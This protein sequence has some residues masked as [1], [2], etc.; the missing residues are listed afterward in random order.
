MIRR[1]LLFVAVL[2]LIVP[3]ALLGLISTEAGSRWLLHRAFT[4]APGQVTVEKTQGRLLDDIVLTGLEYQSATETISIDRISHSWRPAYLL[5]GKLSIADLVISGLEITL[6]KT[7]AKRP[8]PPAD[9]SEFKLPIQLDIGNVLITD[10]QLIR[11]GQVQTV[12]KLQLAAK[13]EGEQFKLQSLLIQSEQLNATATGDVI[14]DKNFPLNLQAD[15]RIKLPDNGVWQGD[16]TIN[17]DMDKLVFVNHLATPFKFNLE[18]HADHV[19]KQPYFNVKGDWQ[20]LVWPVVGNPPQLQSPQGNFALVGLL[21]DYRLKVNGELQQQYVPQA[22]LAFDGKGSLETMTI[23]KLELESSTGVFQLSGKTSWGDIPA[24]ELSATGQQFNPAIIIPELPGSLNFSSRVKGKLAPNNPQIAA[25]IDQLTGQLRKQTV[26]AKGKLALADKQLKVDGLR[27]NSGAN[28][29]AV[30]GLIDQEKGTL[31]FSMDM[32]TLNTL[33]PT[34]AGSLTSKGQV[35]GG[36][37]NPAIQLDAQGKQLKFAQYKLKALALDLDYHPSNQHHSSLSL[38]ANTITSDGIQL[39]KISL[40]GNGTPQRHTLQAEILY[41]HGT[42]STE[43]AGSWVEPR[44]QA[45]LSKLDIAPKDGKSWSLKAKWPLMAEKNPPGFDVKL[46]EGCLVQQSAALCVSGSYLANSDLD[47]Q[48]KAKA[49]PTELFRSFLP[50]QMMVASLI[51]GNV[52]LQRNKNVLAGNFRADTT[53]IQ[54]FIPNQDKLQE[55]QLG[56]STLSGTINKDKVAA[57]FNL[58][59]AGQDFVQGNVLTDIGKVQALSG[60]L[61]AAIADFSLVKPFVP[62]MADIQGV[63]KADLAVQGTINKPLIA[64]RVG[65]SNGLVETDKIGLHHIDLQAVASG[66]RNNVIHIQGSA[67]PIILNP[68]NQDEKISLTS[69]ISLD[70]DLAVQDVMSGNLRLA[71]PANSVLTLASQTGKQD[72]VLG[73]T[74]LTGE[75]NGKALSAQLDMALTGQDKLHGNLQMNADSQALS[76]Q[77]TANIREFVLLEAFVPLLSKVKG[78]LKADMAVGGTV[79]KPSVN[80][81]VRLKDASFLV[82]DYGL[83]IH[84]INL[85]TLAS[86]IRNDLIEIEGSAKSGEGSIKLLGN[87]SLAPEQGYP[88]QL[89]LTGKDFEI[90]KMP[91]AQ[92]AVSPDLTLALTRQQHQISGQLDIPKA[93]LTLEDIPENAVK[94][95]ADEVILGEEQPEGN[96]ELPAP[97]VNVDIEVKLGKQVS[98]SG[99][100]L[101]TNLTGNLK[102]TKPEDKMGMQGNVNMVKAKYQRF[103]QDLTVRKGRF[104]FNGPADNPWLDV[105]AIRVSKDKKVTAI[106]GLSGTLKNPQTHIASE[107]SLPETEALA[108]LVTGGPLNQV[109]KDEGNMLASAALSYGAGKATWLTEKLGID[110]FA[111]EEGADLKDSLLVMGEYLTPDFYVGT[112]VGMFNKQATLVLK[113]KLTDAINVETQAGTSQRIKLNYEF[114]RD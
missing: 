31:A 39:D 36:W 100:G 8:A 99:Q 23:N 3:I 77:A 29:I 34:L 68:P 74:T 107:P 30:D 89:T 93:I 4:F 87:V 98:F 106:L 82:N 9:E 33:W 35:N 20:N 13:T 73:A 44:W 86:P 2:A 52:A 88:V 60:R 59:L 46:Q 90:A 7:A 101:Q 47:Y 78:V 28:K 108:Y 54:V 66:S 15:W 85:Q 71:M 50:K 94:V 5:S 41:P 76:A 111:V 11:D 67:T 110:E 80:G 55:L 91:E 37:K 95:S 40:T 65:L 75:F 72:I 25:D 109:S 18:G 38:V 103:G 19:L 79:Q 16:S 69:K 45:A 10:V 51:D 102:I 6:I 83:S 63:L 61:N 84:D 56:A 12:D 48:L 27:I 53:P 96:T 114:D 105:E 24:F 97:P 70:A 62:Q 22:T 64:G 42:V 1:G 58:K 113:H 104:L 14:L 57:D 49:I 81:S 92:I 112:R 21:A 32:P 43:L 17:G 26:Q